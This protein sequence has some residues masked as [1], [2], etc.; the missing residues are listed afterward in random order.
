MVNKFE[1]T[2]KVFKVIANKFE[3]FFKT[4]K[5]G[6]KVFNGYKFNTLS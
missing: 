1:R 5:G 6:I 3:D 4:L 2:V